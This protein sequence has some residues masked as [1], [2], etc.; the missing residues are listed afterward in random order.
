MWQVGYFAW[1]GEERGGGE[2]GAYVVGEPRAS[3]DGVAHVDIVFGGGVGMRP[4]MV[5]GIPGFGG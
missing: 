1:G 4:V 2:E 3:G 5:A